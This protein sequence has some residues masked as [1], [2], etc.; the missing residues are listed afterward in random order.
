[1][2]DFFEELQEYLDVT[3]AH[4]RD[5]SDAL[6]GARIDAFFVHPDMDV[7]HDAV[8]ERVVASVLVGH[9][10]FVSYF[11]EDYDPAEASSTSTIQWIDLRNIKEFSLLRRRSLADGEV[12]AVTLKLRWGGSWQGDLQRIACDDPLCEEN[13]G[14][15]LSFAAADMEFHLDNRFEPNVFDDGVAFLEVVA[16]AIHG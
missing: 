14:S 7:S 6:E 4:Y 11:E 1:M 15:Y 9:W 12:R 5:M 13:H 8:Y 3:S 10:L 2:R 16:K